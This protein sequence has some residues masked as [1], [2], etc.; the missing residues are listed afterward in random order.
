[1]LNNLLIV[2]PLRFLVLQVDS[3]LYFLFLYLNCLASQRN[4]L[5]NS[6]LSV[7]SILP[8]KCRANKRSYLKSFGLK[9]PFC[10]EWFGIQCTTKEGEEESPEWEM[11][12]MNL[13]EALESLKPSLSETHAHEVIDKI[14]Y[15]STSN[16]RIHS[17]FRVYNSLAVSHF[18]PQPLGASRLS[19]QQ[20][21]GQEEVQ[22]HRSEAVFG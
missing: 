10:P 16:I 17:W 7:S 5:A 18:L 13:T 11:P 14:L 20:S 4:F 22:G 19:T 15:K 21:S 6:V 1:M 12:L 9:S 3:F 2:L 8:P